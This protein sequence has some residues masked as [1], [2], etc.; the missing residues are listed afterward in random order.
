MI[1][2]QRFSE[3]IQS[4]QGQY[5]DVDG[6]YGA[7]CWD[8]AA[9]WSAFLGLPMVN[10]NDNGRWPGWAGNMVDAYPQSDAVAAAYELVGPGDA[11]QA[12]DIAVWGDTFW[13]YPSTHVAVVVQDGAQLLTM[14]QNSTPSRAD[15]PYPGSSTGPATIQHLPKGGLI[16]YLRPRVGLAAQ[17]SVQTI[18][19]D[20]MPITKED[21][22]LIAG[23]VW[24][25]D[26]EVDGRPAKPLWLLQSMDAIIRETIAK[27]AA[28]TAQVILS[29]ELPNVLTG[30]KTSLGLETSWDSYNVQALKDDQKPAGVSDAEFAAI[31]REGI[32]KAVSGLS[33]TLS[34]QK[35]N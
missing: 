11:A 6:G 9:H 28:A 25:F 15:N 27:T 31:L 20:D 30:G 18:Q 10:T 24:N 29:T 26:Y 16:G 3:W 19:E 2:S 34:A 35:E 13:Y 5:I 1:D 22:A 4:V 21:A 32:D 23:Y 33:I 14:S 12:G 17:G 7:Q 8:L